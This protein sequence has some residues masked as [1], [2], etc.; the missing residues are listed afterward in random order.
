MTEFE[1][2][3]DLRHVYSTGGYA[4]SCWRTGLCLCCIQCPLPCCKM[5]GAPG[6]TYEYGNGST[7]L[8]QCS[9]KD[10]RRVVSQIQ[11]RKDEIA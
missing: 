11:Q 9:S 10:S 3:H 2:N 5:C 8:I 7:R 6:V 4:P 1:E